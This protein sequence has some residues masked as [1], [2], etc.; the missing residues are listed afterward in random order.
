MM[1]NQYGTLTPWGQVEYSGI[2][3]DVWDLEFAAREALKLERQI[4]AEDFRDST[5]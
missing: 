2:G 4:D 1:S 5:H 3:N